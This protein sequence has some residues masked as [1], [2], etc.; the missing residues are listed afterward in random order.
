MVLHKQ[1]Y[2]KNGFTIV[3][4]LIVIVVIAILAAI[5]LIAFNG[6]QQ[7]A[8]ESGIKSNLSNAAKQLEIDKV[9]DNRYPATLND[10]NGGR[11]LSSS[12]SS[13]TFQYTATTD[14]SSYCLS[15]VKTPSA[16]NISSG[17]NVISD[18]VCA[19]H[20]GSGDVG[21][22]P[23]VRV[24]QTGNSSCCSAQPNT[25]VN[26]SSR[27]VE[28]NLLFLIVGYSGGSSLNIS[29][30]SGGYITGWQ[31]AGR[32]VSGS[33]TNQYYEI[34]WKVAQANEGTGVFYKFSD[35]SAHPRTNLVVEFNVDSPYIFNHG[36]TS[37]ANSGASPVTN[38]ASGSVNAPQQFN[39][40]IGSSVQYTGNSSTSAAAW[41]NGLANPS[42]TLPYL[43]YGGLSWKV[44]SGTGAK[45]NTVTWPAAY[46]TAAA[47]SVFSLQK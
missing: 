31:S 3:E 17:S 4:L 36:G 12:Q 39:L 9:T 5:T 38:L 32:T 8:T 13:T 25:Y 43:M 1:K 18:G 33:G 44:D 24:V 40:V 28:G 11:G 22:T 41:S 14:G 21:P 45:S 23:G 29:F 27:P 37:S 30:Q 10:A 7:R 34:Y 16:F 15:G 2:L 20:G 19:G 42:Y 47:T 6:V 35:N 46:P 26:M